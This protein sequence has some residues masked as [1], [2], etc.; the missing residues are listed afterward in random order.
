MPMNFLTI[1]DVDVIGEKNQRGEQLCMSKRCRLLN[2]PKSLERFFLRQCPRHLDDLLT[3]N[4]TRVNDLLA[5][6]KAS[7]LVQLIPRIMTGLIGDLDSESVDDMLDEGQPIGRVQRS[8]E[9]TMDTQGTQYRM[10]QLPVLANSDVLG[11]SSSAIPLPPTPADFMGLIDFLSNMK[12]SGQ[13]LDNLSF[14]DFINLPEQDY[15]FG[16][17]EPSVSVP[18]LMTGSDPDGSGSSSDPTSFVPQSFRSGDMGGYASEYVQQQQ[19]ES[20]SKL[21]SPRCDVTGFASEQ[22]ASYKG[23]GPLVS[24]LNEE[25]DGEM[26]I[27]SVD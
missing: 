10:E 6:P 11:N 13:D 9:S 8:I 2:D 21:H 23:K 14:E 12:Y 5:D 26:S 3:Q 18:S 16:L 19:Q 4:G 24:Y 27:V 22:H 25:D 17:D 20:G 15:D 7:E 1:A